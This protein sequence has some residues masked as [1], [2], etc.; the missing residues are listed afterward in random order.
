MAELDE[1]CRR[2]AGVVTRGQARA[3]GLTAG[4]VRFRLRSRRWQRLAPGTYAAFTGDVP[5]A[6]RRWAAVLRAGQG[7]VLSHRSAAEV[8]RLVADGS[9]PVHITIP[10]SRRIAVPPGTVVHRCARIAERRHPTRQPPQT[11]IEETVLDLAITAHTPDEAMGWIAAACGS[12]LT[13]PARV[14]RALRQRERV[15]GRAA[16]ARMLGDVAVG[17]TSVLEWRY[18]RDVERAHG[19]PAGIRQA[20]RP[21]DGGTWY[22]DV[23]YPEYGVRVELDGRAA[24]PAGVRW[25]DFRRDNAAAQAGEVVL[26]YGAADVQGSPCE[27]AGQVAEV[28]WHRGWPRSEHPCRLD[29]GVLGR[30]QYPQGVYGRE[31]GPGD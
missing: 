27:V 1:I 23:H 4:A 2:Q 11:R 18:L 22:D 13:T 5:R 17:C 15:A 6:A 7:A 16:L 19:L 21:R 8:S 10:G 9:G 24:H 25:R 30:R 28:L 20:K 14:A 26:R 12:R 31:C 29:C 3:A